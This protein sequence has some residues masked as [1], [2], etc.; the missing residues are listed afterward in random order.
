MNVRL[1]WVTPGAEQHLLYMARVSNPANQ[2]STNV[3]L[4]KYML[5][6]R[7]WS[8]FEM[9][10][11]CVEVQ[12][13]RDITRQLLRHKHVRMDDMGIQEFSQRYAAVPVDNFEYSECRLQD[14][15]NRQNSLPN[16]DRKLDKWWRATQE[17]AVRYA[18]TLYTQALELGIAKEVAR[19]V[20]PEGLTVS[21]LYLNGDLRR[22]LHYVSIRT[23]PSAQK[24][25]RALAQEI[26]KLLKDNFPVTE[27]AW[28]EYNAS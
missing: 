6:H 7:H 3:G 23:D 16:E 2:D 27:Q 18:Y 24:E 26:A 13:T 28:S 25:H 17:D 19:K 11:M 5:N 21:R 12:A 10:N 22:W 4:I 8:P 15:T 14:K 20:L 9:V 1:I